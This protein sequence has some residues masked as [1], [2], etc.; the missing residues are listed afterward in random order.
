MS[1]LNH[2]LKGLYNIS[3]VVANLRIQE[4]HDDKTKDFQQ[5]TFYSCCVNFLREF[6][7]FIICY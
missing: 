6:C 7:I 4:V 1:N 2:L 5:K 3:G